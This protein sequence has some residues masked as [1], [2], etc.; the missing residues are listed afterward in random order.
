MASPTPFQTSTSATDSKAKRGSVSQPGP[1]IP[2]NASV[3]LMT[4][5][6]GCIITVK[7]MPTPTV[8]TSTGKKIDRAQIAARR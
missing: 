8:E 1:L 5:V 7:V 2:N 3:S 6:V 4:P